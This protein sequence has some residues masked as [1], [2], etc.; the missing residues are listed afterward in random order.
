M[1]CNTGEVRTLRSAKGCTTILPLNS[2]QPSP[3]VTWLTL[4]DNQISFTQ[5]QG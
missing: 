4:Y 3:K 1:L 5:G 2:N